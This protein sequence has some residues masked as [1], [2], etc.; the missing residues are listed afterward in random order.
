MKLTGLLS[1][2]G[3]DDGNGGEGGAASTVLLILDERNIFVNQP[4]I[5]LKNCE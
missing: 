2:A 3:L 4:K 1:K 5:E